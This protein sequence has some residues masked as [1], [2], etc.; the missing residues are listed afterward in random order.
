[1]TTLVPLLRGMSVWGRPPIPM[2]ELRA[3]C[4]EV[5]WT[6]VETPA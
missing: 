4:V 6:G 3:M 2:T 1:V 5:G